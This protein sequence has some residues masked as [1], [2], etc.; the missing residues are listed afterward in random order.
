M[1]NS[2]GQSG[3]LIEASITVVN[4]LSLIDRA[5][6]QYCSK[7]GHDIVWASW[8]LLQPL[9]FFYCPSLDAVKEKPSGLETRQGQI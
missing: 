5:L 7:P 8:L 2:G 6:T 3:L 9:L 4:R 1:N